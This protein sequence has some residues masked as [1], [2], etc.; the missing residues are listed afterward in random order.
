MSRIIF[1]LETLELLNE[2]QNNYCWILLVNQSLLL[3][4]WIFWAKGLSLNIFRL[5]KV[6]G[7]QRKYIRVSIKPTFLLGSKMFLL[8]AFFSGH[9]PVYFFDQATWFEPQVETLNHWIKNAWSQRSISALDPKD[10]IER[11]YGLEMVLS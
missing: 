1:V 3:L 5:R 8:N 9:F 7:I 4:W 10:K 6:L 2:F 11:S